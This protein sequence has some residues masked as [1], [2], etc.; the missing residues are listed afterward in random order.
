MTYDYLIISPCFNENET[1][2]EFLNSVDRIVG[3]SNYSFKVIIVDDAST[4]YTLQ[5]LKA[6]KMTSENADF[7]ILE[8]E[9]NVGHQQAIYQGIRYAS[10]LEFNSAI[11]MD[12]D[13]EDDPEIISELVTIENEDIVHVAR[14]N[15]KEG[16][17]FK[18][19]YH[20]YRAIFLLFTGKKLNFGNYSLI[21][22]KYVDILAKTSFIQ[23]P[24]HLLKLKVPN[25]KI[26]YADRNKRY[27]GKSK[28]K[29][30]S[31]I[32][33]AFKS[34]VEFSEDVLMVFLRIFVVVTLAFI[35]LI[36]YIFYSKFIVYTAI[37][38]WA[39]T[40][41]IGLVNTALICFGFFVLGIMQ[42]NFNNKSNYQS[43]NSIFKIITN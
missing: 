22:K 33:H 32:H 29:I 27:A 4:D 23:Y 8:L 43:K 14:K 3:K 35:T 1:V 20:L 42:L 18:T 12:S 24:A 28:M 34:F 6:F 38:G 41:T 10:E 31:L 13:G 21:N 15:R 36:S 5:L 16:L 37:P 25:R 17:L 9:F 39:S 7:T 19:L 2:I 30:T 11:I 26:I 40:L